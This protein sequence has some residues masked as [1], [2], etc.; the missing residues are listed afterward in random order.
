MPQNLA[1]NYYA[2][3]PLDR[4]AHL[5]NSAEWLQEQLGAPETRFV[6]MHG[7]RSLVRLEPPAAVWRSR[8]QVPESSLKEPTFLGVRDRRAY[9]AVQLPGEWEEALAE[10]EGFEDLRRIGPLLSAE[11]GSILAYARGI[12]HWS[13]RTCFCPVCGTSLAFQDAGHQKKCPDS[14]CGV[15]QFP[16]TDPAVI[17]L[18]HDGDRVVLGR[19]PQ[20]PEGMHSILAG[21]VEPGESLEDA[22]AREVLEEVGLRVGLPRYHSSQPW[23]FPASIMLGFTAPALSTEIQVHPEELESAAWY[24]RKF[25][26]NLPAEGPFRLPRPDS[27]ARRILN[28]WL[29][30]D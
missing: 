25:L 29:N 16:R 24:D 13:A 30:L 28:E 9:F 6:V 8:E 1:P 2:S 5:R 27:I 20:W 10:G 17:M 23:P 15:T 19:Q 3:G 18:V 11:D 7:G 14:D 21:F 12:L 4:A 22:V 26:R